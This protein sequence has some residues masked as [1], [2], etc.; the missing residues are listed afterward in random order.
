MSSKTITLG[1]NWLSHI[2]TLISHSSLTMLEPHMVY[3]ATTYSNKIYFHWNPQTAGA[4]LKE[5]AIHTFVQC[6][7]L[8]EGS[9]M[10]YPHPKIN[11]TS[12]CR[13]NSLLRPTLL[14]LTS[15]LQSQKT[16]SNTTAY[17]Q[18]HFKTTTLEPPFTQGRRQGG[19]QMA[20]HISSTR[21]LTSVQQLSSC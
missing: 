15:I 16:P 7:L 9:L 1:N 6:N 14:I 8:A 2:M 11:R 10:V 21:N 4:P 20:T 5:R 3:S 12:S 18:D 19:T 17:A 13:S